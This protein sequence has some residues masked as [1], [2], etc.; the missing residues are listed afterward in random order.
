[1]VENDFVEENQTLENSEIGEPSNVVDEPQVL[2]SNCK[3]LH[4]TCNL[5]KIKH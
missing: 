4:D 3:K 5:K 1:M 2:L